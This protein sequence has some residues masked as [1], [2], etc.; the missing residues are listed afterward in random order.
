MKRLLAMAALASALQMMGTSLAAAQYFYIGE[1]RLFSFN[2]CPMGWL[3]A[4]GQ[5]LS[6]ANNA[7]LFSL[8]GTT[9]GGDGRTT[10]ALPNLN[11]RAPYGSGSPGQYIG[12]V[13]GNSTVALTVANLPPHSHTFNASNAAPA[14]PSPKDAL[15]ST[16][17]SANI[18]APAGAPPD[19]PMNPGSVG[20]T[21]GAAPVNIQSPALAMNWCIAAT[22]GMYPPRQ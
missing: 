7:P 16:N 9:Y 1:V 11:G 15:L 6:I 14:G 18:Y 13:Y 4:S 12:T 5:I 22:A 19:T 10:F 3:Q 21:G 17:P 20:T 8:I 2:F